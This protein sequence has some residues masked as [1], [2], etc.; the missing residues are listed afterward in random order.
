[1]H[2]GT[3][4]AVKELKRQLDSSRVSCKEV[5][6]VCFLEQRTP[7]LVACLRVHVDEFIPRRR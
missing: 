3:A 5:L 1:M 2:H 7:E 4:S 6:C